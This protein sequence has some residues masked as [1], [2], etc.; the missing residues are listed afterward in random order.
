MIRF[1]MIKSKNPDLLGE[2]YLGSNYLLL[3]GL[4]KL[5]IGSEN[6]A[7]IEIV[8]GELVFKP[9]P[10]LSYFLHNQKRSTQMRH[11]KAQDEIEVG[12]YA[13]KILEFYESKFTLKN[14]DLKAKLNSLKVTQDPLLEV[15]TILS[16]A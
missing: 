13:F 16:D 5:P 9:L 6:L 2:W 3:G 12:P 15:I 4:G 1:E 8:K 11:L 10:S 7:E 14:D